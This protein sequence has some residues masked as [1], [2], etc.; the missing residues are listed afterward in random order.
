MDEAARARLLKAIPY[1]LFA[2]GVSAQGEENA[3]T[4]NWLTQ[5]SGEPP[6]LALAVENSGRSVGM[7][8]SAGAFSVNFWGAGQRREAAR[9]ARPAARVPGKLDEF[10]HR[11]G[12]TGAPLLPATLGYLEC[13]VHDERPSG[14]HT[15]FLASIVEAGLFAEGELLELKKAGFVY[16][17]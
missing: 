17:G 10:E 11:V 12:V 14:D 16:N 9:L 7:I 2:I 5:C 6:M 1:G 4:A 15:L 3:F 8:R 13:R